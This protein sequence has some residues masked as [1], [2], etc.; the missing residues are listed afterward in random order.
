MKMKFEYIFFATITPTIILY[1]FHMYDTYFNRRSYFDTSNF[2]AWIEYLTPG[3]ALIALNVGFVG[4]IQ[5]AI[6]K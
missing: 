1:N 6:L 4:Y 2:F 3:A 5:R